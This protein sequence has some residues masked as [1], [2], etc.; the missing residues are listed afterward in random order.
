M[1]IIKSLFHH[2]LFSIFEMACRDDILLLQERI[3]CI[4]GCTHVSAETCCYLGLASPDMLGSNISVSITNKAL[5]LAIM[6]F[7]V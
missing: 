4:H 6:V 1:D 2:V 7:I 3:T 5:S